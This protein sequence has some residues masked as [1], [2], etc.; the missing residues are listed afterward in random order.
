MALKGIMRSPEATKGFI[1]VQS[2]QLQSV[3]ESQGGPQIYKFQHLQISLPTEVSG[4][5]PSW[6]MLHMNWHSS[7]HSCSIEHISGCIWNSSPYRSNAMKLGLDPM[8]LIDY[9]WVS[10]AT[11]SRW[12]KYKQKVPT[13]CDLCSCKTWPQTHDYWRAICPR[14]EFVVEESWRYQLVQS[15]SCFS[16]GDCGVVSLPVILI[17]Q[18]AAAVE[19]EGSSCTHDVILI[20]QGAAEGEGSSCTHVCAY[21]HTH[22]HNLALT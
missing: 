11:S 14:E 13:Y 5:E 10:N 1:W 22:T 21:T 12:P 6:R 15:L 20:S 4:M 7:W 2:A 16:H 8:F 3:L 18:S 17:S 19:G 9:C